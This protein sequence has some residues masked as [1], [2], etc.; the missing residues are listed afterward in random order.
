MAGRARGAGLVCSFAESLGRSWS[1]PPFSLPSLQLLWTRI[2]SQGIGHPTCR[3][4]KLHLLVS[5]SLFP[6][7]RAWLLRHENH[8]PSNPSPTPILQC[9]L[10][11]SGSR[12]R[13]GLGLSSPLQ[14]LQTIPP[15]ATPSR[16]PSPQPPAPPHTPHLA[17]CTGQGARSCV[18]FLLPYTSSHRPWQR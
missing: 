16:K 10:P 8:L 1:K 6:K 17:E 13:S 5:W 4:P 11:E 15:T 3:C 2:K 12:E 9:S 14:Y 7:G 18:F